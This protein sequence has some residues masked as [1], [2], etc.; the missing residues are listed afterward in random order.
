MFF[1]N[2]K[3]YFSVLFYVHTVYKAICIEG[4]TVEPLINGRY[5]YLRWNFEDK[6]ASYY[7][8]ETKSTLYPYSS[9]TNR[10]YAI[11]LNETVYAYCNIPSFTL[12][13]VAQDCY[14]SAG[15]QLFVYSDDG[16]VNDTSVMLS[17]CQ[18]I[19]SDESDNNEYEIDFWTVDVITAVDMLGCLI[20]ILI[21]MIYWFVRRRKMSKGKMINIKNAMLIS[22]GIGYYCDDPINPKIKG[23]LHDLDGIRIDIDNVIKL[24]VKSTFNYDIF[25]TINY[26][27]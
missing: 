18:D 23:K 6:G 19:N 9:E 26:D 27:Q 14:N 25:P 10:G 5:E 24:F 11:K 21:I 13:M 3:S 15:Q 20:L 12:I 16:W 17:F 4:S 1:F 8:F 22:V 7:N 2:L